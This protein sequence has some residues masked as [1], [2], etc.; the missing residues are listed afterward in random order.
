MA[1]APPPARRARPPSRAPAARPPPQRRPP[2]GRGRRAPP[3]QRRGGAVGTLVLLGLLGFAINLINRMG[4][5]ALGISDDMVLYVSIAILAIAAI[6]LLSS[7]TKA[8]AIEEKEIHRLHEL[9]RKVRRGERVGPP[10]TVR[11]AR[12]TSSLRPP[13]RS[14]PA[15]PANVAAPSKSQRSASGATS[16][17]TPPKPLP[18]GTLEFPSTK[19]GEIYADTRVTLAPTTILKLRTPVAT[20]DEVR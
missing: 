13:T 20:Y 17:Q 15:R 16:E 10:P 9:E 8:T 12:S 7:Y 5:I 6:L 1:K 3:R 2:Q 11:G 4:L 14:T 18:A 19:P